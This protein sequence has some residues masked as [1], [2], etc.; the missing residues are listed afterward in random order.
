MTSFSIAYDGEAL[1][2]HSM[3]VKDLAPALLAVG[4]LFDEANTI[5]NGDNV[6]IKLQVKAT[7]P[8]SF[9]VFFA[10]DQS[11]KEQIAGF[12]AGDFVTS[13]LNLKELIFCGTAGLF[14]LIKKLKGGKPDKLTDLGKGM[15]ELEIDKE[16]F[17]VPLKLLRLYQDVGVRKATEAVL[18]P[19]E[20]EGID[21]VEIKDNRTVMG[22]VTKRDFEYFKTPIIED[23]VLLDETRTAAYSIVSL[24]FKDENKWRLHDG[25]NTINATIKDDEFLKKV[26][27]SL[28]SFSKGDILLCE[29]RTIQ[30]RTGSGL[31]TEYEVLEVKKHQSAARQLLLF[32]SNIPPKTH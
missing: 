2:S 6:S 30:W 32:D 14:W 7:A 11:V 9:E 10:L 1:R 24:A 5:L 18:S 25:N 29:V 23:Y 17:Q 19:L 28:I 12:L 8:G 31:R 22:S 13:A 3:D 15:Y 20:S 4:Q 21:T 16:R 26:S 27:D